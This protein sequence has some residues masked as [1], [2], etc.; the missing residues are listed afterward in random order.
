M[1]L[2]LVT[3]VLFVIAWS[4]GPFGPLPFV[5]LLPL[6]FTSMALTAGRPARWV[7]GSALIAVIVWAITY[8]ALQ[9][10]F[11]AVLIVEF[12]LCTLLYVVVPSA[13]GKGPD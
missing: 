7:V 3:A 1:F 11:G 4:F 2:W 9:R 8:F 10:V 13:A 6:L 5:A 12:G